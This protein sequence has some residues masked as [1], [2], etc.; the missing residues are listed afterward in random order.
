MKHTIAIAVG[1]ASAAIAGPAWA[2]SASQLN[3]Q[4]LAR[5]QGPVPMAPPPPMAAPPLVAAS[6]CPPGTAWAAAGYNRRGKWRP[7]RCVRLR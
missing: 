3:A 2:Q 1:I 6:P 7:A 5:M 4:E